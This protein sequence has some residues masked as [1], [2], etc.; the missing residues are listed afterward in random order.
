MRILILI[1]MFFLASGK[2]FALKKIDQYIEKLVKSDSLE[3]YI[4]A[5]KYLSNVTD[6]KDI[7]VIKTFYYRKNITRV[8]KIDLM[9]VLNKCDKKNSSYW[10]KALVGILPSKD[11]VFKELKHDQ[12]IE[13][14][15]NTLMEGY[16]KYENKS[17]LRKLL[18][19]D[20]ISDGWISELFG[21]IYHNILIEN[22]KKFVHFL[23]NM[24]DENEDVLAFILNESINDTIVI[25]TSC[26]IIIME[27]RCKYED[28]ESIKKFI[29]HYER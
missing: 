24:K 7:Q 2:L 10:I 1:I 18:V 21:V 19:Y 23:C 29:T 28:A 26:D 9:L 13:N 8:N 20:D 17:A 5:F 25:N 4:D 16:I 14:V 22:P 12:R 6:K 11:V 15:L 27:K 3:E